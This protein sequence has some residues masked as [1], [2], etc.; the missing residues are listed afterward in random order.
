MPVTKK[1]PI[2]ELMTACRDYF[3]KTGR[4]ITFEYSLI[5]G[6]NDSEDNALELIDLIK[7]INCHVN[8]ININPIKEKDFKKAR[9]RVIMAFKNKLEK[10]QINVTIR[11]AL[12]Q[13]IDGACGQ[14]RRRC[15]K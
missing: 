3:N 10:N 11:R 12:G 9:E 15:P 8:L 5:N 2:K 6:I 4:R 13:D 14:L 7:D 1:Y